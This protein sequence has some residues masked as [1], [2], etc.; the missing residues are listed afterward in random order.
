MP[1]STRITSVKWR[2]LRSVFYVTSRVVEIATD[3]SRGRSARPT[4]DRRFSLPPPR[5]FPSVTG[6][7][8]INRRASVE[9]GAGGGVPLPIRIVP[10]EATVGRDPFAMGVPA[11]VCTIEVRLS[12]PEKRGR[13]CARSDE[14]QSQQ[15]SGGAEERV[16]QDVGAWA[17]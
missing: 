3:G 8:D 7:S 2:E 16:F 17:G 4:A 13:G 5:P 10:A 1:K 6:R 14:H 11:A 9:R 12:E 15:E